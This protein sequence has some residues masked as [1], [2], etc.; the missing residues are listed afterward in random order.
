MNYCCFPL[1]SR[2]GYN[3]LGWLLPGCFYSWNADIAAWRVY[4]TVGR[5]C[6]LP[7]MFNH[8]SYHTGQRE[9]DHISHRME[10]LSQESGII[11]SQYDIHLDVERLQKAMSVADGWKPVG[12]YGT[13]FSFLVP[14]RE[15]PELLEAF[16]E[17]VEQNTINKKSVEICIAYDADD[18]KTSSHIGK[19]N[20]R[21][22]SLIKF[23]GKQRSNMINRDYVNWL[24]RFSNG[25]FVISCNDDCKVL[26]Y[27]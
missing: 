11:G 6:Y 14:T 15:R 2:K 12:K 7:I 21:F 27:G 4:Q 10:Q 20:R 26:N 25:A 16:I 3:A 24:Y 17:S 5:V 19:M 8:V 13:V 22:G 18:K 23:Y 1:F 9:R